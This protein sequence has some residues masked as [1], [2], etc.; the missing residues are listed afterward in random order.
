[1]PINEAIVLAPWFNLTNNVENKIHI[2]IK[3]TIA[4]ISYSLP[5]C[6]CQSVKSGSDDRT[7]VVNCIVLGVLNDN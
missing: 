7:R 5:V 6:G 1:M 4:V 2:L 3:Y